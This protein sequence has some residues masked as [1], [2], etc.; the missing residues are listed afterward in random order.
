MDIMLNPGCIKSKVEISHSLLA[1]GKQVEASHALSHLWKC[2]CY[3]L[4]LAADNSPVSPDPISS[5]GESSHLGTSLPSEDFP[6]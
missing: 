2:A 5:L 3:Q 6:S 4:F 1:S